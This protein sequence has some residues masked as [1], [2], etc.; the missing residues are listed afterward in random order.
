MNDEMQRLSADGVHAL[1]YGNT[2]HAFDPK[3]LRRVASVRYDMQHRCHLVF[4]DGGEDEGSYG[5]EGDMYWTRYAKFR[6]GAQCWFY[7]VPAGPDVVQAF[8]ADG[9]RAFL[10]SPLKALA[11]QGIAGD[12]PATAGAPITGQSA[13]TPRA[14]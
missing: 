7:L 13:G 11:A 12:T 6:D 1:L 2:L 5:F 8:H 10:Q 9:T 4:D 14:R 3:S